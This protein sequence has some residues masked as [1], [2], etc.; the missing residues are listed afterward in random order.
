MPTTQ[1]VRLFGI[2]SCV[3]CPIIGG[4]RYIYALG[5][6]FGSWPTFVVGELRL[7]IRRGS[8]GKSLLDSGK[9]GYSL[10]PEN[11]P[12]QNRHHTVCTENMV[13]DSLG[14]R[15][16]RFVF[17]VIDTFTRL[18]A[19]LEPALSNRRNTSVCAEGQGGVLTSC[20]AIV[21]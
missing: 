5:C 4:V 17:V 14:L 20:M 7:S 16:A 8:G 3:G 6:C 12:L 19:V 9:S 15:H 10:H 2:A 11:H 1:A 13:Y 18:Y 21:V